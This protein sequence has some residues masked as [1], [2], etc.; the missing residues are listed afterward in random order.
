MGA[1]GLQAIRKKAE[2]LYVLCCATKGTK[3]YMSY[4]VRI[5]VHCLL[6]YAGRTRVQSRVT[7]AARS[8]VHFRVNYC[9]LQE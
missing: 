9:M 6:P 5:R 7:Y 2:K 3:P 1:G 4:A 8:R